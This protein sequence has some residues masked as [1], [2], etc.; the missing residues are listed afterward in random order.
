[1]T[2]LIDRARWTIGTAALLAGPLLLSGCD[3]KQELLAPQQPQVIGPG[4]VQGAT[5]AKAL[6]IGALGQL[7]RITGGGNNNQENLWNLVGLMTDE[8][9]SGDTF[10]QRNEIDQRNILS[11]N[12]VLQAEY[13]RIQQ[14]RGYA[15]DAFTALSTA[16]PDS[17]GYI[18]EMSFILGFSE[19]ILA[20]NFCNGI[21]FG[22]TVDGNPVYTA[23]ISN[24]DAFT[25]AI[26]HLD[27]ALAI[28]TKSDAQSVSVKN[29][30]TV[31]KARALVGLGQFAQAAALVA[32]IPTAFQY[33]DTYAQT[34]QDNEWW[35][36]T[37]SV[38][39]YSVSDSFDIVNGQ[40]NRILNA[41]PFASAGDPRVP[42]INS[43]TTSV[44]SFD[45]ITPFVIQNI[46]GRDD[47]MPIVSGLD[48]RLIEAEAK[49]N[50]P[51]IGGMMTILNNLR[52]T[53]QQTGIFKPPLMAALPTPG[54]Q[55]AA[56]DL[57]FRE[58]AFWTFG[59]GQRLTDMR[60]M[61]R[62]YG[63]TQDKVFPS[64]IFHKNGGPPYGS[65]VNFPVTD[66]EKTNPKFTGCLDRNA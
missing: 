37:T 29:A 16:L 4:D 58:K 38:G 23:P 2:N 33:S 42:V 56:V 43:T 22:I 25:L 41:I 63:R 15:R 45:G 44:K 36:M 60:R 6:R 26:T 46:W 14:T 50:V 12:G 3:V 47:P 13:Q 57:F 55:T 20:E 34:S 65:D 39:R 53:Q 62:Q 48:A 66:S 28:A 10:S 64:G 49:L 52:T 24:K 27:S 9:K 32:N 18:G 35:Q 5:G 61:I 31:A 19:L 21:P 30:T 11:N 8:F 59:R 1:M 40:V 51:D 7:Q 17:T 54:S